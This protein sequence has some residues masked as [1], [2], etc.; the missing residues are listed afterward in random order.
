MAKKKKKKASSARNGSAP[1]KKVV[2]KK[3]AKKEESAQLVRVEMPLRRH[4][5]PDVKAVLSNHVVIRNDPTG[6]FQLFFFD[7]EPPLVI[8]GDSD[9]VK[10]E[11]AAQTHVDANCVSRVVIP[12]T[13]IPSLI[14][15][16]QTNLEKHQ[17]MVAAITKGDFI[18][19]DASAKD[20]K[21]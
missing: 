21:K 10:K 20:K 1:R 3:S 4:V 6:L 19:I 5:S 7:A 17:A 11:A 18:T 15:A 14:A 9:D 2:K 8:D 13:V 12:I 16:L